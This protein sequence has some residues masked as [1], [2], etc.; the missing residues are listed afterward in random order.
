VK[1][2]LLS[3]AVAGLALTAVQASFAQTQTT[4]A[5]QSTGDLNNYLPINRIPSS[6]AIPLQEA[7]RINPTT[8]NTTGSGFTTTA[9]QA[10]TSNAGSVPGS[11]LT[12]PFARNA[13]FC[14]ANFE[15]GAHYSNTQG[16]IPN[17]DACTANQFP[18]VPGVVNELVTAVP[19]IFA[20]CSLNKNLLNNSSTADFRQRLNCNA[21]AQ[22]NVAIKINGF[23]AM[24]AGSFGSPFVQSCRLTKNIPLQPKC[25]G[26]YPGASFTQF[27]SGI[28]TWW[29]LIFSPPGTEF[30]LRV[31]TR[32]LGQP[33]TRF[34]GQTSVHID[35]YHFKVV[36]TVES[37]LAVIDV[38]HTFALGTS[39]I[40]C[41]AAEDV[42]LALR[43]AVARIFCQSG[44][45][46]QDRLFV[47]EALVIAFCAFGDCFDQDVFFGPGVFPPSNDVSLAGAFGPTGIIDTFE[48][49]CCCKLLVDLDNLGSALGILS[50]GFS[51]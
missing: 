21:F 6:G 30:I 24:P 32:C 48:N 18:N 15:L 47:A 20:L 50:S 44:Q 27:G 28:R 12:A 1:K 45:L 13:G 23:A 39:E 2:A 38:L 8:T 36:V 25:P 42:Y 37:L 40:P 31:T 11:N 19:G 43:L 26:V 46:Q 34:F 22:C 35:E 17:L 14:G 33:G 10:D 16:I 7:Y 29:A 3:L 9:T 41:I 4:F 49:P 51:S 5:P